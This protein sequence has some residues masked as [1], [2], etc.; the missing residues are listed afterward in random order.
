MTEVPEATKGYSPPAFL[1]SRGVVVVEENE[2][3]EV[4]ELVHAKEPAMAFEYPSTDGARRKM[5]GTDAP[6]TFTRPP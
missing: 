2:P 1:W 3:Y 6:R 4:P 5:A